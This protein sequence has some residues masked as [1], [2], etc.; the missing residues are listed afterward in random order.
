M[1]DAIGTLQT[2]RAQVALK[3]SRLRL[4]IGLG[5]DAIDGG[6]YSE[7][8]EHDLDAFL[9]DLAAPAVP[10]AGLARKA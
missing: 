6:D 5:A 4:L 7:V 2:R 9:D 8:E 3:L 1:H 10:D